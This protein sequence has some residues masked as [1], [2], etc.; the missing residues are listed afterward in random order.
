M[1]H[2]YWRLWRKWR[3]RYAA[4]FR[5]HAEA[6]E[7]WAAWWAG[8][9]GGES[10]Q[11]QGQEQG[12]GQE[13]GKRYE[14]YGSDG[15]AAAGSAGWEWE[16]RES[17][18]H[19]RGMGGRFWG[20]QGYT[21]EHRGDGFYRSDGSSTNYT[22]QGTYSDTGRRKRASY[23]DNFYAGSGQY[24]ESDTRSRH[25]KGSYNDSSYTGSGSYSDTRFRRGSY[26]DGAESGTG[27]ERRR[28]HV[29]GESLGQHQEHRSLL[30]LPMEGLLTTSTVKAA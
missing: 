2:L 11:G 17:S 9:V 16:A 20:H 12:R 30:G 28:S 13:G 10:R 4:H 18:G 7:E 24:R 22:G 14:A 8:S 26:D 1:Q 19:E 3:S 25:G 15:D 23:S 29:L 6:E 21:S 27:Q 5:S